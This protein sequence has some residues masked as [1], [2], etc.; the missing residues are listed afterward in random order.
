MIFGWLANLRA[1]GALMPSSHVLEGALFDAIL[2]HGLVAST[3][4]AVR[5]AAIDLLARLL[6]VVCFFYFL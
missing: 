2:Q 4:L 1:V 3:S 6:L 5:L